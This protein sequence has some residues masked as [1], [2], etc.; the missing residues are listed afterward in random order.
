M[1]L[2]MVDGFPTI[3]WVKI[4]QTPSAYLNRIDVYYDYLEAAIL[5]ESEDYRQEVLLVR[6][7]VAYLIRHSQGSLSSSSTLGHQLIDR[8]QQSSL[9]IAY[10]YGKDKIHVPDFRRSSKD[11]FFPI[12]DNDDPS[13]HGGSHWYNDSG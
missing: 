5:G 6:P 8:C 12:N 9:C 11:S 4:H 13:G 1:L 7:T 10:E 3:S 2:K